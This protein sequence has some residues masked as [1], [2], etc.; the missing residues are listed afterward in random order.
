[1]TPWRHLAYD[2]L[3]QITLSGTVLDLGGSRK[4]GYHELIK[5]TP[6]FEVVNIDDAYGYDHKFDLEQPFP[7]TDGAYDGVL[8]VNV[9]EHLY[10]HRHVLAESFRVLKPG[11]TCVVVVPFLM[12]VHPS[13]H[14]HFRYTGETLERLFADAGFTGVSV[15]PLGR[16]P[17]AVFVQL[18]GGLRGGAVWRVLCTPAMWLF[19][20]CVACMMKRETLAERFPLG[21]LVEGK[22]GS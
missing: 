7:L 18:V 16:G 22:K 20:R 8:A 11:G 14:D 13:P 12:F 10:D 4:S 3:A 9:L 6:I 15:Q 19:D 2:A 21:Y 5:G 17:G 1:M